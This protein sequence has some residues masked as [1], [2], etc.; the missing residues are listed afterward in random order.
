MGDKNPKVRGIEIRR[1]DGNCTAQ[2]W[3]GQ[4]VSYNDNWKL[5]PGIGHLDLLFHFLGANDW[6]DEYSGICQD[7]DKK[8]EK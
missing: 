3:Y 8:D 2:R 5:S 7:Y 4:E 6:R 1:K